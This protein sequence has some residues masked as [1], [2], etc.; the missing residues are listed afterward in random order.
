MAGRSATKEWSSDQQ[1]A[2]VQTLLFQ[3]FILA[4]ACTIPVRSFLLGVL[5]LLGWCT[6]TAMIF[7]A[8]PTFRSDRFANSV[9]LVLMSSFFL[10]AA[11]RREIQQ[12]QQSATRLSEFESSKQLQQDTMVLARSFEHFARLRFDMV[13]T[14]GSD[15]RVCN[16][17]PLQDMFFGRDTT[18]LEFVEVLILS[19]DQ[20]LRAVEK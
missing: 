10:L 2:D 4:S 13:L 5:H 15:L 14:L 17:S 3:V 19:S 6:F 18:N 1:D 9:V 16:S 12:Q 11:R 7:T 8:G 20:F